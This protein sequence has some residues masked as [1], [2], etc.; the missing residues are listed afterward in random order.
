MGVRRTSEGQKKKTRRLSASMA[1]HILS[2]PPHLAV[3]I[4][5]PTYRAHGHP[6]LRKPGARVILT[7]RQL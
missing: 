1:G 4:L 7:P 5:S 6:A 2:E 3:D